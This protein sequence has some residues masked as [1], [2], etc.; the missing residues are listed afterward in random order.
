MDSKNKETGRSF[1]L[2][3]REGPAIA[4]I[5]FQLL[6]MATQI[7]TDLKRI[8]CAVSIGD[9]VNDVLSKIAYFVDEAYSIDH[10]QLASFKPE[11]YVRALEQ[12]YQKVNPDVVLIGYTMDNLELPQH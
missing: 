4:P 9:E 7:A 10:P 6:G 5:T 3:G 11:L 12:L 1:V 8:L 2:V